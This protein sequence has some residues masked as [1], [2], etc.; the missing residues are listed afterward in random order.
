MKLLMV[1]TNHSMVE[2]M[3]PW[4]KTLGHEVY[5][6][7]TGEQAKSKWIE[8]QPDLVIVD[9]VLEDVDV[10]EMCR[11]LQSKCDALVIMV[12]ETSGVREEIRCLEAGADSYIRKPFFPDQLLAHIHALS[13]RAH[14][15]VKTW[16]SPIVNVGAVCVDSLHNEVRIEGKEIRLTRTE[17]KLLHLLA[18]NAGSVCTFDQIVRNV[19]EFANAGGSS[20]I[21]SHIYHLRQ[22]VEINPQEPQYILTV[23]N[24]GY[25]LARHGEDYFPLHS[26]MLD[27]VRVAYR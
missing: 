8:Y 9:S 1:D 15:S 14:P 21:R 16:P 24:I 6:A 12:S 5:Y 25:M 3:V 10:L 2:M 23:P 17:A 7:F 4:L 26:N 11:I 18:I 27:R 22:K 13:R 19:W 20:P